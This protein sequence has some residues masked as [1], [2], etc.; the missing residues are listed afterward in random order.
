MKTP[1]KPIDRLT[2]T[3]LLLF[4]TALP[5]FCQAI[6]EPY[7]FTTLAGQGG[8]QGT[9]DGTGSDARFGSG[10]GIRN[11]VLD[12]AGNLYVQD[13]FRRKVTPTGAVTTEP[14]SAAI[15]IQAIDSAGY[16][17]FPD[18]HA[19]AK[20]KSGPGW[21]TLAGNG[22]VPGS[23]DGVGSAVRF[24]F[25]S[26]MA[27]DGAG[28]VYVAD[29]GNS[30]IRKV[31]PEG[32]VTTLA[33]K[34]GT[35]GTADG[36]GNAARFQFESSGGLNGSRVAIALDKAGNLYVPNTTAVRKVTP[37]GVVTTLAGKGG[38]PG[39]LDG[40][41]DAARFRRLVGL[42][43]DTA[44]NVYVA[45]DY[46]MVRKITPDGVVTTLAGQGNS[47]FG[48]YAD[49]V[50]VDARFSDI[51]GMAVD[52][53]GNVF[54]GDSVNYCIRKI[55]PDG[56]VTTFAGRP[57]HTGIA[58]GMGT[59]ARFL[60]PYAVAVDPAGNVAVAD[61]SSFGLYYYSKN[62]STDG[63]LTNSIIRK[64]SA[65]GE[66]TTLAGKPGTIGSL[67]GTGEAARFNGPAGIGY[68]SAGNLYVS[69]SLNNKIRKV[70]PDGVVTT[71]AD[72][73]T[74]SAAGNADGA[75]DV[76]RFS[77]PNGLAV[78]ALGN[79][80]VADH[81][82]SKIRKVTPD[83]AVTTLA[84]VTSPWGVAVDTGGNL[85][86][87]TPGKHTISK[88][89]PEGVVSILAGATGVEG[90]ADGPRS[91]AR[92]S[93][94]AGVAV[95]GAGNVYVA[96]YWNA[97]VRKITAAG[98]VTT[99]AGTSAS[100]PLGKQ[101]GGADGTGSSV[102][103]NLPVGIA[104]DKAGNLCVADAE[105]G[106]IR[107]GFPA[108]ILSSSGP[109]FGFSGGRFGFKLTGQEG[110]AVVVEASTDL[111]NWLPIWT[112]TITGA[113]DFSDPDSSAYPIRHYR[114]RLP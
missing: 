15:V 32:V 14:N 73:T 105:K 80:F 86:V 58:D 52:K 59:A 112:N 11:L 109:G 76:A 89:T 18:L 25:P 30:T 102:R 38:T 66:V 53:A 103:F 37:E 36:I 2:Q 3:L 47:P 65:A 6:Y 23:T 92:F 35:P 63:P 1:N 69:D 111:L 46:T 9:A 108:T 57:S 95:D 50:G 56:V 101:L 55:T 62:P 96:D 24:R 43:V 42:T 106:T 34:A 40:T 91:E 13:G 110:R 64:V 28:K 4:L 33:G 29:V 113:L 39:S 21:I 85:Y 70:T 49:G 81:N 45:D 78:D 44:G 84:A 16:F 74:G 7:T 77:H 61:S 90:R 104:V 67:N 68:D 98:R 48:S 26:G 93:Y 82:N 41:G 79:V 19:V 97:T 51:R 60:S 88:V 10:F 107:K 114:A 12:S 83:G 5:A 31:T 72:P 54:V 94:P 100:F 8:G 22:S 71:F 17:Y 87:S 75:A 99:L 27:V 20:I